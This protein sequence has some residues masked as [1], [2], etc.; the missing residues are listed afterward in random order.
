MP[1]IGDL[2][3]EL[4]YDI[5]LFTLSEHFPHTSRHI[6]SVFK[7]APSS[8]H[9]EYLISRCLPTDD[10]PSKIL[11]YPIC[12][13]PILESL[14]R[15]PTFAT[16]LSNHSRSS[17][18]I[19]RRLFQNLTPKPRPRVVGMKKRTRQKEPSWSAEDAPMPLLRFLL[20]E[21]RFPNPD[22]NYKDGYPLTKAVMAGF[23]PLIRFLLENGASP[24]YKNGLAVRLAI[25]RKDLS[26]V[27]M[28]IEP[29]GSVKDA[30]G[31]IVRRRR[32]EDRVKV[33]TEMV[34]AAV[35]VD[36]RDIVKYLVAE[37]GCVPDMQTVL[38]IA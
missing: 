15:I 9:A 32:L 10:L 27:R 13:I 11:R 30:E 33:D 3:V 14:L 16:L 34:K 28:L 35:K 36:A 19:P 17:I 20:E 8:I 1:A 18:K 26:L 5:F 38:M 7:Q 22:W 24:E 12:T 2:P 23:V 29:D 37:K 31:R 21:P 4:L 25:T 6:Y